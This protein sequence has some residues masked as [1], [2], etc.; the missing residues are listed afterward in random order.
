MVFNLF[1]TKYRAIQHT[2]ERGFP[3][4]WYVQ[5]KKWFWRRWK[6]LKGPFWSEDMAECYI[7]FKQ[8]KF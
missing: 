5:C 1:R 4:Q 8:I 7:K 2:D 3:S 6:F